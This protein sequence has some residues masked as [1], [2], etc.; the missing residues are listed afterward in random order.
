MKGPAV[1]I[2]AS[3][4]VPH[5]LEGLHALDHA[6]LLKLER[7]FVDL[8][9]PLSNIYQD[10]LPEIHQEIVRQMG[11]QG[12]ETQMVNNEG[13]DCIRILGSSASP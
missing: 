12:F 2:I 9:A 5:I 7:E 1:A 3:S 10:V 11:L 4:V 8:P 13:V 6:T